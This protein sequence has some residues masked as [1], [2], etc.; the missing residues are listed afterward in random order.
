[1]GILIDA[2][3]LI[4]HERGR[5][6]LG[7]KVRGREDEPFF[8]SIVT[9]SELLHGVH[10]AKDRG[11]RARR[12][13]FVEGILGNLPLLPIEIATARMHAQLWADLASQ[14]RPI[15]AHDLWIAASCLSH[16]LALVTSN[17]REFGR[18]PG[19]DVEDW[20]AESGPSS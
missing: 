8:L 14:G 9:A 5:I 2:S 3:V 7:E 20:S 6:D 12:S 10:R 18:V 4:D 1:M 15:G 11:I 19:L 17:V 13:A 16:G